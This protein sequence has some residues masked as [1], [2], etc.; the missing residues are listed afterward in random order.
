MAEYEIFEISQFMPTRCLAPLFSLS[1]S[2]FIIIS[3]S[4]VYKLLFNHLMTLV[5]TKQWQMKRNVFVDFL[6]FRHQF[7]F[8]SLC[9][10]I[11]QYSK[12]SVNSRPQR[13]LQVTFL[14][15]SFSPVPASLFIFVLFVYISLNAFSN[16]IVFI[17]SK[18]KMDFQSGRR[19]KQKAEET[20][21]IRKLCILYVCQV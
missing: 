10:W 18:W 11:A 20:E 17:L 19:V 12:Q 6:C 7:L 13:N 4:C 16:V 2:L 8:L 9:V 1:L 3:F 5:L 15:S 21:N 14:F